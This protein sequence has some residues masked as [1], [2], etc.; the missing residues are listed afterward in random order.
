[1]GGIEFC[2]GDVV[3][4]AG[5]SVSRRTGDIGEANVIGGTDGDVA[6]A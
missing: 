3:V 5:R 6:C 1:M 2:V 4:Q